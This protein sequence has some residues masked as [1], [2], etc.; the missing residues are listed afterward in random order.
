MVHGMQEMYVGDV[1]LHVAIGR[2][3]RNEECVVTASCDRIFLYCVSEGGLVKRK[4]K[5]VFGHILGLE[6]I[7][8]CEDTVG[9]DSFIVHFEQA[10]T[11]NGYFS[12]EENDFKGTILRYF[13]KKEYGFVRS[14]EES[15]SFLRVDE[16]HGISFLLLSKTHFSV[17]NTSEKGNIKIYE[18]H[19]IRPKHCVLKDAAFL[20]GYSSSTI[21]FLF[22]DTR[23]DRCRVCIYVVEEGEKDLRPFF[24]IEAIPYGCYSIVPMDEKVFMVLGANGGIFY[25]QWEMVGVRFNAFWNIEHLGVSESP[26]KEKAFAL[27]K[28]KAFSRGRN[29]FVF[30]DGI[31]LRFTILGTE[32]KIYQIFSEFINIP[33]FF[34]LLPYSLSIGEK[35]ACVSTETGLYL[36]SLEEKPLEVKHESKDAQYSSLT[37]DFREMFIEPFMDLRKD[38]EKISDSINGNIDSEYGNNNEKLLSDQEP[39]PKKISMK[40]IPK[41]NR[42]MYE[43][44]FGAEKDKKSSHKHT[45]RDISTYSGIYTN[46]LSILHHK[47]SFGS[48]HSMHPMAY[49][50]N[51]RGYIMSTGSHYNP[52]L[53]EAKENVEM[54]FTE[55]TKRKGYK[56]VFLVSLDTRMYLL[57]KENESAIFKWHSSSLEKMESKIDEEKE[58]KI[59]F[60]VPNGYVQVTEE[61]IIFLSIMLKREKTV[62]IPNIKSAYK[63]GSKV[64]VLTKTGEVLVYAGSQKRKTRLEKIDSLSIHNQNIFAVNQF[65][66][67]LIYSLETQR[68]T[69]TSEIANLFPSVIE[70]ASEIKNPPNSSHID[71][72]NFLDLKITQLLHMEINKNFYLIFRTNHN[73]VLAYRKESNKF[74]REPI[75][76][77]NLYYEAQEKDNS[78]T[79]MV[80]CSDF[81]SIPGALYTRFLFFTEDGLYMHRFFIPLES[82]VE[83]PKKDQKRFTVLTKLHLT[84]GYLQNYKYNKSL[85]YRTVK[86]D[87][88]SEKV[89]Y[90]QKKNLIVASTYKHIEYTQEMVPYTVLSTTE[91][92]APVVTPPPMPPVEIKPKTREYSLKIFSVEE[93]SLLKEQETLIP[94]DA[95]LMQ[96]NEYISY[97]KL[98]SLP[99]KQSSSGLSE[100]IAV[101]TT[102]ITDED[103]MS[104]GRLL[105]FEVASVV[106]ERTRKESKHKLKLLGAEKTKGIATSCDAI[107]GNIAVTV[108]TKVLVYSFNQNDGIRAVAFQDI[109]VFLTS[110]SVLRNI[111]LCG[112]AYKG[113]FL[114]FYQQEPPL[115]HLLSQSTGSMHMLRGVEMSLYMEQCAVIGYDASRYIYIYSYS[116]QNILSQNGTR[117]IARSE[118]RLPDMVLGSFIM[119][120]NRNSH[121]TS[122]FYTKY[123]Y[124][125]KHHILEQSK[126]T[127]LYD[128]QMSIVPSICSA[129]GTNPRAYWVPDKPAEMQEITVKDTIQSGI[130]EEYFLMSYPRAAYISSQAGRASIHEVK[131]EISNMN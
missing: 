20:R 61:N 25:T 57:T 5:R 21:C 45:A 102:Y 44:L 122:V 112:D 91:V 110:C 14:V 99:D 63:Y 77:H 88:P 53:V 130:L 28:G 89:T 22:E 7:K 26:L 69:F 30:G 32:G 19:K 43:E 73:E 76:N 1:Q 79:Q 123:G 115:L 62:R 108:G 106:P 85:L 38:K 120:E 31:L 71:P 96:K 6:R 29:I 33:G 107:C 117:L 66:H 11:A 104:T 90:Y 12:E 129:L 60:S 68:V 93:M 9:I 97:H 94:I 59:F 95:H 65:G 128:I 119:E 74:F 58:T 103:L 101:C 52:F 78:L 64:L 83:L 16:E 84:N 37:E 100:Y 126:Y 23:T 67:L 39:L 105:L 40:D 125:Y 70:D 36:F 8:G 80:S 127:A 109:Q 24:E 82:I 81:V 47:E 3:I 41:E 51:K 27:D 75:H 49:A 86:S 72:A 116:P 42:K 4:E 124:I 121:Y 111:L 87:S 55:K 15:P 98:L 46:D 2:F 118:C 48:I 18:I 10:R 56:R 34:S 92:D 114:L 13:E 50:E 35:N 113:L 54:I 17:F 131:K